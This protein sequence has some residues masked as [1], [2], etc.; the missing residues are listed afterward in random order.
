MSSHQLQF[1]PQDR[2]D[3]P[4]VQKLDIYQNAVRMRLEDY[5][6]A[7]SRKMAAAGKD[8]VILQSDKL[9]RNECQ[10]SLSL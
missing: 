7:T 3:V 2:T 9:A 1:D 5:P 10:A 4:E 8:C 6:D